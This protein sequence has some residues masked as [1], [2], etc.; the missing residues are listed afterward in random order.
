MN[1]GGRKRNSDRKMNTGIDCTIDTSILFK[2]FND[3]V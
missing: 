2:H 1:L 3:I